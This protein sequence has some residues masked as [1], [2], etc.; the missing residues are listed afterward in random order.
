MRV[1]SVGSGGRG[2]WAG[3]QWALF[4]GD[5]GAVGLVFSVRLPAGHLG[6]CGGIGGAGERAG[7]TAPL[8]TIGA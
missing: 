7:P 4:G 8:A 6:R 2:D 3:V 1:V 5:R